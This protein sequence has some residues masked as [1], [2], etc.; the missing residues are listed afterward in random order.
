MAASRDPQNDD[1]DAT[2]NGP[3]L[4][5]EGEGPERLHQPLAPEELL[6]RLTTLI[7]TCDGCE[8][9][10][11]IEVSRLEPPDS[12]GCNWSASVV[13]DPAGVAPEVYALAYAQVMGSARERW[14]L[15]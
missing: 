12:I 2:I 13:L 4:F 15:Q 6:Q 7:Q 1:D 5:G 9:V 8:Q 14:N 10:R 3:F 11:V